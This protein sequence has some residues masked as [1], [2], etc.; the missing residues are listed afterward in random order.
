MK[1]KNASKNLPPSETLVTSHRPVTFNFNDPGARTV[2]IAGTF[3]EWHASA[4]PMVPLG[5]GVWTKTLELKP[6]VYEYLFVVDD[7]WLPDPA[8]AERQPN[9]FGGE[10]SVLRVPTNS[11]P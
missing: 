10:N 2:S 9:P 1:T 3:N 4:T 7:R 6:G 11:R 8:C 5:N